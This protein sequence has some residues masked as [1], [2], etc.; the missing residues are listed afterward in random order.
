MRR[1]SKQT[2]ARLLALCALVTPASGATV[3]AP[4][5]AAPRI[6][7]IEV[8]GNAVTRTSVIR[9]QLGVRPGD[10]YEPDLV[11]RARWRLEQL[12]AILYADVLVQRP[13][14][15]ETI[16]VVSVEEKPRFGASPHA[17]YD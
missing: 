10:L 9:R 12:D 14:P 3:Q 16:L 13:S 15:D 8:R 7:R 1:D 11:D 2:A 6:A 4:T 17:S 5:P